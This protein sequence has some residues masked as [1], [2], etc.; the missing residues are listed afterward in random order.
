M[1]GSMFV[2]TAWGRHPLRPYTPVRMGQTVTCDGDVCRIDRST[3]PAPT[4][5]PANPVAPPAPAPSTTP[6]TEAESFPIVPV[7][8]GAGALILAAVLL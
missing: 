3:Q 2:A 8:V 5:P 6:P 7:A 1:R 4:P